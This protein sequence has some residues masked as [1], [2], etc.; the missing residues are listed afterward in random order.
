[1]ATTVCLSCSEFRQTIQET[2]NPKNDTDTG[3][4]TPDNSSSKEGKSVSGKTSMPGKK[5]NIPLTASAGALQ[6]AEK[7][8]RQLPEFQ[9]K[10]IVV[11]ATTHFYTDGRIHLSIQDPT[12]AEFID[13]YRYQDGKWQKHDP[14]RI[15]RSDRIEGRLI[16][17]DDVPFITANK[18]HRVFEEKL[19]EIESGEPV[20]TI[21]FSVFD[22]EIRW[23]PTSLKTDRFSYSIDFNPDGTLRSF[24]KD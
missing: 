5:E 2:V 9:D 22:K 14:V 10:P 13:E 20:P 7:R 8:L 11:Y 19:R 24:K 16:P 23:Y 3:N 15:T 6:E 18:V 12:N 17:L 1:M 21:Y 4:I